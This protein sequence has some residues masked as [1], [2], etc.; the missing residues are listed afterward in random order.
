[1]G[2]GRLTEAYGLPELALCNFVDLRPQGLSPSGTPDAPLKG[3]RAQS[4]ED[5]IGEWE[6]VLIWGTV[7]A[8]HR[9]AAPEQRLAFSPTAPTPE[10]ALQPQQI[11]RE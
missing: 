1:M 2:G 10:S 11:S 4:M 5:P 3:G 7:G 9:G 6:Q 8:G